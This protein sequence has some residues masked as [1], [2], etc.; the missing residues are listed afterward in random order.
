M[1]RNVAKPAISH[2]LV[3][4]AQTASGQRKLFG[5]PWSCVSNVRTRVLRMAA[6]RA[7]MLVVCL[8]TNSSRSFRSMPARIACFGSL[9]R[10]G[11]CSA[12]VFF[13]TVTATL[14][15]D[16]DA[17]DARSDDAAPA[18]DE[19][20]L[21]PEFG[22]SREIPPE[23]EITKELYSDG[24]ETE[25]VRKFKAA[26]DNALKSS[27]LS[28]DE[29]KALDAAAKYWVYRLTM[30][31]Y[32]DEEAPPKRDETGKFPKGTV[33]ERLPDLRRG[34]MNYVRT[35]AKTQ[36]AREYLLKQVSDRCAELLDNHLFVRLNA[37]WLLG[38]LQADNGTP[39]KSI[40]PAPYA[41]AYSVLLK[42]LKDDKQHPVVK[43]AAVRGLT[44]ICRQ[45]LPELQDKRRPEIAVA[46]AGELKKTNT[47]W[48]YQMAL[49]ECLGYSSVTYDPVAKQNPVI[50]QTLGEVMA[51]KARHW[52][53][54]TTAAWAIGRL[55]LD[56]SLNMAP[57]AYELVNLG[58]QM[59]QAYNA[60]PKRDAWA[61][62]YVTLY[63]AFKPENATVKILAGKRKPGLI[64]AFP[65]NKDIKDAYEQI[66][67]MAGHVL[68]RNGEK[69]DAGQLK[70]MT[71]WMQ[72]HQPA[73]AA[74]V[75]GA[76]PLAKPNPPMPPKPAPSD[77][78]S[79][80]TS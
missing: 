57:V 80:P 51:D 44:R 26:T 22:Q 64:D 66:V 9:C 39:A 74:I 14:G 61:N 36:V 65:N 53:T 28:D 59:A 70:S 23:L 37:V 1:E 11:V 46:V 3:P 7:W 56:N 71:N 32:R 16:S 76:A 34:L 4:L 67:L 18:A 27:N 52:Q 48:W 15:Q 72:T 63:L 2:Y 41:G 49:A 62:Y 13:V 45:G 24:E 6:Q 68:N 40:D 12:V 17:T 20:K 10:V 33:K 35:Y 43:I 75:N 78:D 58:Q 29:K 77:D 38:Q 55:P 50:L 42:V 21:P 60:N 79:K 73:N 47:Y 8:S 69:F 5:V 30:K 54:R 31:K 25:Y 19:N